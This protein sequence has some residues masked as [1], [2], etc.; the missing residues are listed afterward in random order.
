MLQ[1]ASRQRT[2][3]R[4]PGLLWAALHIHKSYTRATQEE[5]P[6]RA[7]QTQICTSGCGA[8]VSACQ[9]LRVRFVNTQATAPP[10]I[11]PNDPCNCSSGK[12]YKKCCGKP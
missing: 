7:T 5:R 11:G 9:G 12:K 4:Q 3:S 8:T 2:S 6:G 1:V 10:K